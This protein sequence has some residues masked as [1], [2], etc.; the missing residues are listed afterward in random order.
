[1]KPRKPKKIKPGSA[2]KEIERTA[3]IRRQKD[4]ERERHNS[5]MRQLSLRRQKT[6]LQ[7]DPVR[8]SIDL[9]MIVQKEIDERRRHK[10]KMDTLT[11][12]IFRKT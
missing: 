1:M 3:K 9:A 12:R 2:S 6:I 4:D 10:L 11:E 8:R 5:A 7:R